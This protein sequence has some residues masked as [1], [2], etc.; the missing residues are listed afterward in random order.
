MS[1]TK[2]IKKHNQHIYKIFKSDGERDIDSQIGLMY[3]SPDGSQSIE[4]DI[5]EELIEFMTEQDKPL[6]LWPGKGG[7]V[8]I[9]IYNSERE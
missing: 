2:M 8:E 6:I 4:L 7:R 1:D 3:G 9:E 5:N